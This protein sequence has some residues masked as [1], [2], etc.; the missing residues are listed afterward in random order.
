MCRQKL[1]F[2]SAFYNQIENNNHFLDISSNG[3]PNAAN[4]VEFGANWLGYSGDRHALDFLPTLTY[5]KGA[6]TIR[7]GVNVNFSQWDNP[8]G[9]NGNGFNFS[10]NFTNEYWNPPDAPGYTSGMSDRLFAARLPELRQRELEHLPVLVSALLR[11]VGP[12]RLEGIEET[13]IES[14]LAL[15][16]HH[17]RNRTP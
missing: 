14:R 11:T 15:G 6:H 17:A 8:E 5:I 2:A 4:F 9:G 1:G 13:D 7:A 10:S 3:L 16:L 12:G